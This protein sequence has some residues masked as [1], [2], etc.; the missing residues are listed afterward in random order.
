[1]KAFQINTLGHTRLVILTKKYAIKVTRIRPLFAFQKVFPIIIGIL[2]KT[3]EQEGR[4]LTR[5]YLGYT[6]A[7]ILANIREAFYSKKENGDDRIFPCLF[8]IF[9]LLVVQERGQEINEYELIQAAHCLPKGLIKELQRPEQFCRHPK[10]GKIR[11]CDYGS[12]E[13]IQL[14]RQLKLE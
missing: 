9:G 4:T 7:G 3:P 6:F 2:K 8:S 13:T 5:I 10:D 1:M 14:L 11:I 12:R